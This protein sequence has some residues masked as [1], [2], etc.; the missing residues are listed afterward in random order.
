MI[1]F[2][3]VD[4]FAFVC[5]SVSC[6]DSSAVSLFLPFIADLTDFLGLI[7]PDAIDFLGV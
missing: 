3:P 6:V 5:F 7:D 4:F 2:R 1:D